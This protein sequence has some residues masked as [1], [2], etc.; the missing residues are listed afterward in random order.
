MPQDCTHPHSDKV[1]LGCAYFPVLP[2]QCTCYIWAH[3][4]VERPALE[5]LGSQAF[6]FLS[7]KYLETM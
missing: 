6:I 4:H 5:C 1:G 2:Q 3:V 7:F